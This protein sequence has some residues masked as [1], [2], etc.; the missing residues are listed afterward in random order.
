MLNDLSG[1]EQ[2]RFTKSWFVLSGRADREKTSAHP[3]TFPVE[4]PQAFVKFFTRRGGHV[5][6]PFCGTGA[7]LIAAD[8]LGLRASGIEIEPRFAEFSRTGTESPVHSGDAL[9]VL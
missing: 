8:G 4:I 5:L 7:T 3:A 6:D 9:D 1:A 2:V